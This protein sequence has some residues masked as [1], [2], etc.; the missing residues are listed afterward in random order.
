MVD[1]FELLLFIPVQ[2]NVIPFASLHFFILPW[3]VCREKAIEKAI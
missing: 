1:L 3:G 2:E